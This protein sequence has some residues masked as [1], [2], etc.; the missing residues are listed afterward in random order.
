MALLGLPKELREIEGLGH[1]LYADDI[2]L[3]TTKA[4]S[5]GWIQDTLQAAADVVDKYARGCGLRC[6]P[7]KSALVIVRPRAPKN[8]EEDVKVS[9]EGK[10]ILPVPSTKILGLIIQANNRAAMSIKKLKRTSEQILHMLRRVASRRGGMKESDTLRLV[11]AFVVSRITYVTPYL[12]LNKGDTQ[13]L[14]I[15]IRKAVKQAIGVPM[16]TS[17]SKLL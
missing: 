3:W 5:S 15:I 6:S 11:Q 7:E 9:L 12:L 14:D 4:G 17:T 8:Q 16:S 10:D 2:S 1:A 13:Q